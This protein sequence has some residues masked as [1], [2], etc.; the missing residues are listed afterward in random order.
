MRPVFSD[1]LTELQR[2]I[3]YFS[4]L[5]RSAK[6]ERVVALGNATKL[7]G[8]RRYLSQNLGFEIERLDPN[9]GEEWIAKTKPIL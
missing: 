8:L 1:L 2:S 7:P 4:S 3:G 9:R 6:I 5:D